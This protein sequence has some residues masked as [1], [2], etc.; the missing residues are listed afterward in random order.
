VRLPT[1]NSDSDIFFFWRLYRSIGHFDDGSICG[2]PVQVTL[3]IIFIVILLLLFLLFLFF[4]GDGVA[5]F[6]RR[7]WV[8]VEQGC[9]RWPVCLGLGAFVPRWP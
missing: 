3:V 5:A 4:F 7:E 6:D 1:I 9:V 2:L 8:C